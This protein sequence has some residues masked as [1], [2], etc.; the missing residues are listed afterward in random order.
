MTKN[1][2]RQVSIC[3]SLLLLIQAVGY[4]QKIKNGY[5]LIKA[6]Y[7][8]YHH[9][10]ARNITFQQD[11]KF[12]NKDGSIART[13]TWYE[14]I[15]APGK[16][17]IRMGDYDK[18]NGALYLDNQLYRIKE[19]KVVSQKEQYNELMVL[20]TDMFFRK[21]E[22][23]AKIIEKLGFDLSKMHISEENSRKVYVVGSAKSDDLK[24]NQFWFDAERLYFTRMYL[25]K[26]NYTI[27]VKFG[28]HRK[29]GNGWMETTVTVLINDQLYMSEH[30]SKVKAQP[31]LNPDIFNPE[32]FGKA[33]WNYK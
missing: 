6:V 8:K 17:H 7:N 11:T 15:Q 1:N 4:S 2:W 10:A 21:P 9:T 20:A 31:T 12:Y 30:Y 5:D 27:E 18:G 25:K 16:L 3:A 26:P 14:A 23:T 13:Q 19:G 32:K 22:E 29:L 28:N 24:T 33:N